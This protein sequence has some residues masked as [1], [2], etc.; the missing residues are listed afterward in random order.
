MGSP[1]DFFRRLP[2][3]RTWVLVEYLSGR[4]EVS[5]YGT[6][7]AAQKY[8]EKVMALG[9]VKSADVTPKKKLQKQGLIKQ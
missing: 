6:I 3:K 5:D 4:K 2:N 8:C 7:R 9:T 1:E